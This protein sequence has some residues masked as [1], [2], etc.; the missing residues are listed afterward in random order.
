MNYQSLQFGILTLIRSA[1]TKEPAIIP[2]DFDYE[3]T[4]NIG[5]SHQI[6]SLL[7]YGIKN[8]GIILPE[9]IS[10]KFFRA[11]VQMIVFSENQKTE[12]DRIFEGFERQGIDYMPLKGINLKD[13]YP[14]E[15]IRTMGDADIMIRNE[16]YTLIRSLM[17]QLG[18]T[19]IAESDHE[20]VWDKKGMLQVELH[21]RLIPSY[22]KDYY[23]HFGDGWRMA[24]L[25]NV[26]SYMYK[27]SDEDQFVY[28]FTHFSKHYRDAGI[29][30]KHVV[31]LWVY[32]RHYQNLDFQYIEAELTKLQLL[33]FYKNVHR[34]IRVWFEDEKNDEISELLS[35]VIFNSGAYGTREA[36]I[37]SETVKAVKSTGSVRITVILKLWNILFLNYK[38]MCKKYP[39]LRTVPILLPVMW[40]VRL[41]SVLLF[42]RNSIGVWKTDMKLLNEKN[43]TDYHSRLH[44]VGLD[45]N[46]K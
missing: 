16:Q 23:T 26:N 6:V 15:Y 10:G 12:I 31:D 30:I 34:L 35:G 44:A 20:L 42:N 43:I 17:I 1:I 21:K 11:T 39:I 22:N 8:S 18:Y 28:L 27:L 19:E 13:I 25:F 45:F 33:R 46:F 38:I 2:P 40:Q 36:H 14:N 4:Y 29:G 7:Y 3:A 5:L 32:L 41:V 24:K 9:E 37:A